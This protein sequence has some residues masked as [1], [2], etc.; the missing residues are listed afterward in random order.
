M[1]KLL[2]IFMKCNTNTTFKTPTERREQQKQKLLR[3]NARERQGGNEVLL[4]GG[5]K[6]P[7]PQ[8]RQPPQDHRPVQFSQPRV[9]PGEEKGLPLVDAGRLFHRR[10][11]EKEAH[12]QDGLDVVRNEPNSA[13]SDLE[14]EDGEGVQRRLAERRLE[15]VE[16]GADAGDEEEGAGAEE[17]GGQDE[18]VK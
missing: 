3:Q 1:L 7:R 18:E 16:E 12:V 17:E 2:T 4:R 6:P 8:P 15:P 11:R 13:A 9:A 10:R 5:E 14:E